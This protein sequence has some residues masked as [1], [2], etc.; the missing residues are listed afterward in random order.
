[1]NLNDN[2]LVKSKIHK[3]ATRFHFLYITNK[4]KVDLIRL[5]KELFDYKNLNVHPSRKRNSDLG[6]R[7]LT[8]HVTGIATKSLSTMQEKPPV[9]V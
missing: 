7:Y 8:N 3:K 1:M 5:S 6:Q 2:F 4:S 9:C